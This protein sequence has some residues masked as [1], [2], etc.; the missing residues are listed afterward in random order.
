MR[1][2]K[3]VI[4]SLIALII[5]LPCLCAEDE[6]N[7]DLVVTSS[8]F[9]D[10]EMIPKK[11]SG[12]GENIS[13]EI[14][15]SKPPIGTKCMAI[16]CEDPDAPAG[17]WTHWVAFNIPHKTQKLPENLPSREVIEDGTMQGLNDF[18]QV[19]YDGPRPPFGTH[20]YYFNVYALD[21]R[22]NTGYRATREELLKAMEGNILAKGSLMGRYKK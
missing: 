21:T 5:F 17:T 2:I 13:P 19:G 12:Y 3:T 18:K 1:G 16:I 4:I 20:R 11:Y 9:K 6:I 10:G 7:E 8:A 22:V 14:N 15:W